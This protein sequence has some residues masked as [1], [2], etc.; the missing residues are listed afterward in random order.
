M[1][2]L[3]NS[4]RQNYKIFLSSSI[5]GLA[6]VK[7]DKVG[8][9]HI[10]RESNHHQQIHSMIGMH[11]LTLKEF[12]EQQIEELLWTAIDMKT[13]IKD[14]KSTEISEHLKGR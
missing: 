1:K 7:H 5:R 12:N 8:T 11:L 6:T 9:K 3:I 4:L 2:L 14:S 10:Q 13:L